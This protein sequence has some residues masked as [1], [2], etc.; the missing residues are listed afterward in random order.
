[1]EGWGGPQVIAGPFLRIPYVEPVETK[2]IVNGQAITNTTF[3]SHV[4]LI[5]PERVAIDT[6]IH[7]QLRHRSIYDAAVFDADVRASGVFPSIDIAQTGVPREHLRPAL[8]EIVFALASARGLGGTPPTIIVDNHPLALVPASGVGDP[9]TNGFS[10]SLASGNLGGLPIRFAIKFDLRGS[11]SLKLVPSAQDTV[12]RVRSPWPDP[13]FLGGFLPGSRSVG[14]NGFTAEWRVG[15]LALGRRVVSIDYAQGD[16]GNQIGVRLINPVNLYSK[17]DC[18]VKYGF[19]IIGAT[20]VTLALFEV[21]ADVRISTVGYVLVGA[22]LV[23]FF[24]LLLALAEVVGF[25]PAYIVAALA[26]VSLI[27]AYATALL[28][29]FKR[30]AVVG[31]CSRVYTVCCTRYSALKLMRC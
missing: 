6:S 10:G 14:A 5:A 26:T 22:A 8:A 15:N 28:G 13:S 17:V 24:V 2:T 16:P 9:V 4:L 19:L 11:D 25:A 3:T 12:W 21:L 31:G 20:L 1:M 18:S 23:L 7:S 27:T 30:A 29:G